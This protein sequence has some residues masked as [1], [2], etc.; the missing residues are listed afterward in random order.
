MT[1]SSEIHI[2][3]VPIADARSE[4]DTCLVRETRRLLQVKHLGRRAS[5][6]PILRAIAR[7][8]LGHSF[9]AIPAPWRTA[10]SAFS[11]TP[12]PRKALGSPLQK[13][14][15]LPWE[16]GTFRRFAQE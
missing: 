2:G 13:K 4:F 3:T 6:A 1:C 11:R 7:H 10:S 15:D 9:G 14:A 16:P 8:S 5:G 12:P